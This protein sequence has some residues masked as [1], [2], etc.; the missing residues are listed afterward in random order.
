MH[1]QRIVTLVVMFHLYR[2]G[3]IFVFIIPKQLHLVA[4]CISHT[5]HASALKIG[6]HKLSL[7]I[8]QWL[9]ILGELIDLD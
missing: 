1:A 7:S 4:T 3:I 8:C 9:P 2:K 5:F 6:Q